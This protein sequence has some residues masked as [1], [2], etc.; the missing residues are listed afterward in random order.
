MIPQVA[1]MLRD[2]G[3]ESLVILYAPSI[4]RSFSVLM[5]QAD[6]IIEIAPADD[7]AGTT[8]NHSSRSDHY[9]GTL[10]YAQRTLEVS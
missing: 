7:S 10:P 8:P 4:D 5:R 9:R 1:G 3:R 2:I 6:H